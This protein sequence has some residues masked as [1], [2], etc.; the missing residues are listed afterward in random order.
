MAKHVFGPGIRMHND[1]L[2]MDWV[3][4][5]A[6]Y[7]RTVYYERNV[8]PALL[9]IERAQQ[10]MGRVGAIE[11]VNVPAA[12][13]RAGYVLLRDL[14][15]AEGRLD[16]W[17]SFQLY[18]RQ[19][20]KHHIT[21]EIGDEYLPDE[22]LRRRKEHQ[23]LAGKPQLP[24]PSRKKAKKAERKAPASK[25]GGL[26]GKLKGKAARADGSYAIQRKR[27]APWLLM[28]CKDADFLLACA[29][30]RD[31]CADGELL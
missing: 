8:S 6:G 21:E 27:V 30:E 26:R 10:E 2:L 28:G 19:C 17:E 22:V 13:R 5:P 4:T 11:D 3:V 20:R 1:P 15:E 16:D 9:H 23:A 14:Y 24:P 7:I 18:Q 25:A 12:L 29:D 31:A